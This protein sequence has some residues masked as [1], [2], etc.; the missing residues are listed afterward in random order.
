MTS[1]AR[2]ISTPQGRFYTD[3]SGN[4]Y[5]SVTNIIGRMHKDFLAPWYAKLVATEAVENRQKYAAITDRFGEDMAISTL[6]AVVNK[7]H[8]AAAIGTEVHAA[9]EDFHTMGTMGH[10]FSTKTA[11][12]MYAQ[13]AHFLETYRPEVIAVEQTLVGDGYVGT[14]D[15]VWLM[16]GTAMVVDFKT[17]ANIHPEAIIQVA[18][19]REATRVLSPDGAVSE[20]PWEASRLGVLHIRPRSCRLYDVTAHGTVA[21]DTFRACLAIRQWQD[22]ESRYDSPV[23][24]SKYSKKALEKADE[25]ATS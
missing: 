4:R 22:A 20:R 12:D 7:E 21:L 5:P 11:S 13:Y 24:E 2:S 8:P 17:G 18:A 9:I 14:A 6:K 19:L 1:P 15:M 23:A 16:N 25:R 3:A 10:D